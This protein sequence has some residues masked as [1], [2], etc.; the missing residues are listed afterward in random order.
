MN[1]TD[2]LNGSFDIGAQLE[3]LADEL[4]VAGH[5]FGA[6]EVR[7]EVRRL[8]GRLRDLDSVLNSH[9]VE[10]YAA[11]EKGSAPATKRWLTMIEGGVA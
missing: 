6:A 5:A 10:I 8:N 7:R 9:K 2:V 3:Q 1:I 4:A 11:Q